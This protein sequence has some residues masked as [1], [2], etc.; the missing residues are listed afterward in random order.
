[1]PDIDPTDL[2]PHRI[3]EE[4]RAALHAAD[5]DAFDDDLIEESGEVTVSE[6]PSQPYEPVSVPE[7]ETA[8]PARGSV[9]M[10][11]KPRLDEVLNRV[12]ELERQLRDRDARDAAVGVATQDRDFAAERGQVK[13]QWDAEIATL[14]KQWDDGDLD[15]DEYHDQRD[16]LTNKYSERGHALTVEEARHVAKAERVAASQQAAQEAAQ[17]SWNQ[18]IAEWVAANDA[19]M[20]NPIRKKAVAD[21]LAELDTQGDGSLDDDALIALMQEQAFDAFGWTAP[22]A[23]APVPAVDPRTVAIQA[24]HAAAARAA[25]AASAAPPHVAGGAGTGSRD[26]IIDLEQIKP[27]DFK[28]IPESTQRALLGEDLP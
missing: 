13:A 25:A 11:P 17:T 2:N 12:S 19:F 20:A 18:K 23:R 5:P 7:T 26:L 6:S 24:R 4:Q 8:P 28:K 1:M 10:I 15:A 22:A 14:K 9:P 27:G 21:L 16:A 3:T